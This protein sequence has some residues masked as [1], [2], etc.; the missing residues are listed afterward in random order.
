MGLQGLLGLLLTLHPV[1]IGGGGGE[2][3]VPHLELHRL[4][5][6]AVRVCH[7]MEAQHLVG[8]SA[9]GDAGPHADGEEDGE[10]HEK[11]RFPAVQTM[12][13]HKKHRPK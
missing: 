13:I 4:V 6:V 12:G 5:G 11:G 7:H 10:G 9:L 3:G 1:Q 8:Q 2:N